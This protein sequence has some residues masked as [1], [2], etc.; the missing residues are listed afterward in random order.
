MPY[1]ACFCDFDS[2]IPIETTLTVSFLSEITFRQANLE[3]CGPGSNFDLDVGQRSRSRQWCQFKELLT[4]IMHAK[5][6]CSIINTS[7][8]MSQ[9]KVFVQTE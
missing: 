1:Q 5:Y 8:N 6:Q 7:E 2:C 4:R 3:N 9:V